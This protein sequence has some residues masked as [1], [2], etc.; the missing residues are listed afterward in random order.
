MSTDPASIHSEPYERI[1]RIVR[2]DAN[3]IARRW[4]ERCS[5]SPR[6]DP[7]PRG[8]GGE[9]RILEFLE[10]LATQLG[11]TRHPAQGPQ[12]S[13]AEL[14][15]W[16]WQLGWDLRQVVREYLLLRLILLDH[17]DQTCETP[18]D[19]DEILAVSLNFD[20]AI[21][22]AVTAY[23]AHEE[24]LRDA[25]E[26]KLVRSNRE[27]KRFAHVVAHELKSPLNA[28]HLGLQVIGLSLSRAVERDQL[29]EVLES[30]NAAVTQMS[31]LIDEL[32]RYAE[33][34][35]EDVDLTP[36]CSQDVV[37]SAVQTLQGDIASS[38]ARVEFSE[39]PMVQAN[40][41]TLGLVFQN[42]IANAI[43]YHRDIAPEIRI[44]AFLEDGMWQFV[45]A[46]NGSGIRD[47]DRGRIF[48]MFSRADAD[49]RREGTGIGLAMCRQI[50]EQHGGSIWVESQL[51]VG[52]RFCFTLPASHK[53][54][55]A[56][57]QRAKTTPCPL[58]EIPPAR[59]GVPRTDGNAAL[60]DRS[61]KRRSPCVLPRHL[62]SM[63]R[64]DHR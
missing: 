23:V 55:D 62:D 28:Q 61:V 41:S 5:G 33:V 58:L 57:E 35:K 44:S 43:H 26:S 45:V 18:L 32:L 19:R 54:P 1:G 34:G 27:L 51:G 39:L 16:R 56:V 10:A 40:P 46:D 63:P 52:S 37:E 47:E 22:A 13:A 53:L 24:E 38:R 3:L 20:E 25:Y 12:R 6:E 2:R 59:D 48:E 21:T 64:L 14:G 30:T 36:I 60:A 15:K 42:L 11:S 7:E 29:D 17:L 4:R 8:D 50:V 49:S 31:N 9:Q